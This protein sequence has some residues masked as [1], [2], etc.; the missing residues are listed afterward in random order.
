MAARSSELTTAGKVRTIGPS[1]LARAFPTWFETTTF[2]EGLR[3]AR[4]REEL[5]ASA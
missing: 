1:R 4:R 2:A 5:G 3:R